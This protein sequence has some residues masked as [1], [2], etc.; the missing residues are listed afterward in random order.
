MFILKTADPDGNTVYVQNYGIVADT[1]YLISFTEEG[2]K[3]LAMP[4]YK[5]QLVATYYSR[6]RNWVSSLELEELSQ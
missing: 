5:A 6:S 3:A 1:L 2:G 4:D